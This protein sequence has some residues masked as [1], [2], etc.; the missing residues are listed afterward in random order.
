VQEP[1]AKLNPDK[2]EVATE[3]L[4]QLEAPYPH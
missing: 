4:E 1:D 2:Q 3:A